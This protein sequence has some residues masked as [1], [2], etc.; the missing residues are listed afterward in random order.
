MFLNSLNNKQKALFSE[1]A[2]KAAESNGIVAL[3]QKDML[4]CFALEMNIT[5]VY[6]TNR[7]VENIIDDI[8]SISSEKDLKIILFEILGIIVSDTVFD[9][10]EKA[11]VKNVVE[12]CNMNANLVDKMIELLFDY[13]KVYQDIVETVL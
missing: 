11:F 8:I 9:E 6:H 13:S 2:I 5:P 12:K 3:E 1:L 7:E 10:K 4:K